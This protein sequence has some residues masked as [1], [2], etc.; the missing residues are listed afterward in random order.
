MYSVK[1]IISN[2]DVYKALRRNRGINIKVA[3]MISSKGSPKAMI[4]AIGA[5]SFES[6][7][8]SLNNL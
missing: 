8:C 6:D 2:S 1:P 3:I 4:E 5:K 7:S